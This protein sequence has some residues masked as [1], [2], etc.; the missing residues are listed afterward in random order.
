MEKIKKAFL[1]ACAQSDDVP[2]DPLQISSSLLF[3]FIIQ[4][5]V[6][7]YNHIL[8]IEEF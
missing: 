8:R 3:V 5:W 2:S 4:D 7:S 6:F 1:D